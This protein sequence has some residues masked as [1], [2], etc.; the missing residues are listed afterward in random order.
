MCSIPTATWGPQRKYETLRIQGNTNTNQIWR[1]ACR[2]SLHLGQL[3]MRR[4]RRMDYECL[5]ISYVGEVARKSERVYRSVR[6][7][8]IALDTKAQHAAVCV[9]AEHFLGAFVVR[10]V[11]EAQI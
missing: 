7:V 1:H 6:I 3:L 4:R 9:G 10:V 5:G 11:L 8:V 2:Q